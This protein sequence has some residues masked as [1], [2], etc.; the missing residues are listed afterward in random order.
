MIASYEAARSQPSR[1]LHTS[2]RTTST[3]GVFAKR[4][5]KSA[6]LPCAISSSV[7]AA[8][9]ASKRNAGNPLGPIPRISICGESS[10]ILT[11][12]FVANRKIAE[13]CAPQVG[14]SPVHRWQ[15]A[16]QRVV[17]QRSTGA[18]TRCSCP[19]LRHELLVV[20]V[21]WRAT[22]A[23]VAFCATRSPVEER[24]PPSYPARHRSAV[25]RNSLASIDRLPDKSHAAALIHGPANT[26]I[27]PMTCGA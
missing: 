13:R 5:L 14:D 4:R 21:N 12:Q 6:A 7:S 27:R 3:F 1:S 19:C 11:D 25:R 15:R 23:A 17:C 8:T 20:P 18:G 9:G 10:T 2:P 16:L 26:S 24:K 22:S